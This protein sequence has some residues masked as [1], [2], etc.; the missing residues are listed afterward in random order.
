MSITSVYVPIHPQ[1]CRASGIRHHIFRMKAPEREADRATRHEA[2][3]RQLDHPD[4]TTFTG[5]RGSTVDPEVGSQHTAV[6]ASD[7]LS[8]G[9]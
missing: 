4:R 3:R 8:S 7:L 6:L 2:D 1:T 9:I 5:A